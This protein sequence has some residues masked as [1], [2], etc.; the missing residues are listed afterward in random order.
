MDQKNLT[1]LLFMFKESFIH[2]T[3]IDIA[4]TFQYSIQ[5]RVKIN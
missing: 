3:V 5:R 1:D 2:F 4:K